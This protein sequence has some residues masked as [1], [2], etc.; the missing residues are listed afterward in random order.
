MRPIDVVMLV[1]HIS[2]ELDVVACVGCKLKTNYNINAEIKSYYHDFDNI[3]DRYDPKIVVFPF[4]YGADHVYPAQYLSKWPR[5]IFVNLA[6]EQILMKVDYGLKTPRDQ[7]AR[8]KI[9]YICWSEL[10]RDFMLKNGVREERLIMAGNPAMK[11]Y[12]QPYRHYFETR[13]ELARRHNID[14]SRKWVLFP[15]SYQYAFFSDEL[16]AAL[17]KDQHAD[18]DLLKESRD[19]SRRCVS[20]LFAWANELAAANDP[21]FIFRPRPSTTRDAAEQVLK[22][23]IGK[24]VGHIA[25]IKAGSVREWILAS[26]HVVSSHSTTL[27]EAALADKPV[28]LFSPEAMPEA[29]AAPW[30]ELVPQLHDRKA[31][32]A[33]IRNTATEPSGARL[34]EWARSHQFPEPDPIDVIARRI[35]GLLTTLATSAPSADPDYM[36]VWAHNPVS[37]LK[38]KWNPPADEDNFN[39]YDVAKRILRWKKVL[40]RP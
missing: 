1:E 8:E 17:V 36:H 21:L 11:L 3:F 26:D 22:E 30:H 16:L 34:A 24:P 6:W 27:I 39:A 5:A 29:L 32:L 20:K 13:A 10:F 31:F 38:R 40:N 12:D 7:A 37:A 19:Y 28:H 14:P 9:N 4:F 25:V 2:R 33:A 23:I 18:P 35:A 15:E